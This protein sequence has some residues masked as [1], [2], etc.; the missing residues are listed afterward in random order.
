MFQQISSRRWLQ[1]GLRSLILVT[2]ICALGLTWWR[3]WRMAVQLREAHETIGRLRN[4]CDFLKVLTK[5]ATVDPEQNFVLEC[6]SHDWPTDV[7]RLRLDGQSESSE[8]LLFELYVTDP[9]PGTDETLAVVMRDDRVIDV[10]FRRSAWSWESHQAEFADVNGDG[11]LDLVFH[12]FPGLWSGYE[13]PYDEAFA[14]SNSGFRKL[15]RKQNR[16]RN[17]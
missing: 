6:A 7:K 2:V 3:Q 1:F 16:E 15:P 10:A 11:K 17:P 9:V 14:I 8:V 12:C 4:N 13:P 5:L